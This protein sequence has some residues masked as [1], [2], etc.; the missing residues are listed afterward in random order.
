MVI[1]GA[2]GLPDRIP[3]TSQLPATAQPHQH[4]RRQTPDIAQQAPLRRHRLSEVLSAP[5][6]TES[7]RAP[8]LRPKQARRHPVAKLTKILQSTDPVSE[9]DANA[10]FEILIPVVEADP[11]AEFAT[12]TAGSVIERCRLDDSRPLAHVLDWW[13]VVTTGRPTANG[14]AHLLPE[15]L[16]KSVR[17]RM[18]VVLNLGGATSVASW[19][20]K[21][22]QLDS[23]LID[24]EGHL[25]L[26]QHSTFKLPGEHQTWSWF[27]GLLAEPLEALRA[28]RPASRPE[29]DWRELEKTLRDNGVEAGSRRYTQTKKRCQRVAD[30]LAST[31]ALQHEVE[32]W[33]PRQPPPLITEVPSEFKHAVGHLA[34]AL[35]RPLLTVNAAPTVDREKVADNLETAARGGDLS[36]RYKLAQVIDAWGAQTGL[37]I[38]SLEGEL[39][40][41]RRLMRAVRRLEAKPTTPRDLMEDINLHVLDNDL[42]EAEAALERLQ[43]E[44]ARRE[45][46]HLARQQFEGLRLKLQES[47]LRDDA[48]WRER[49]ENIE[50]RLESSDPHDMAREIGAAQTEISRQLDAMVH[51]QQEVLRELGAMLKPLGADDLQVRE[52]ERRI[53]ELERRGGRGAS[54][55]KSQIDNTLERMRSGCRTAAEERLQHVSRILTEERDDF[56]REDAGNFA[57]RLSEI[58]ALLGTETVSDEDL[59]DARDGAARL[60]RDVNDHRIHRW[61]AEQGEERL[62]EHLLD[63]CRGTLDFDA[64]DVRRLYVSLKTR[65]FVI[66]AGLTGSGKSSLTRMYAEALGAN[67]SNG[68]FRRIAVRP[69]WI[70]QTEV[71]GFVNPVSGSFVPGWLAETVRDCER[72]PDR[73]HFVLLGEMNLAPVEQYLAEWLSALEEAR[74]GSTDVR[75]P[76]YSSSLKPAN[77]D[78]W[79][80]SLRLPNNLIIVGTVNVDETTRPLSERVID[81]ANVLLLSVDMSNAHHAANGE[82]PRPWHLA[83]SEWRKVCTPEPSNEHHEFLVE[84]AAILR[85]ANIGV[86]LRAHVELERFVANANKILDPEVALDWGIVQRIIPK[87]RGFKGHLTDTLNELLEEFEG[88]G[89]E[90]SAAIVKRWTSDRYSDDEFLDGTDPRLALARISSDYDRD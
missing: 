18:A 31:I 85:Q 62:L 20:D 58:E 63:F 53:A 82:P 56:S 4:Q 10:A 70:D 52:W 50:I 88:V 33:V 49:I 76:L 86:G 44:L 12:E 22:R 59:T 89:A 38:P 23:V 51:S 21:R 9:T 71:L 47:S 6:R 54:E 28:N 81:R 67:N 69:D 37:K 39:K 34:G 74:S 68:R 27:V 66:L 36:G 24:L 43:N 64:Q 55:L 35:L 78:D 3:P 14:G 8:T 5:A 40:R 42:E 46:A 79:P 15:S 60:F 65:P 84:I 57:S 61:Q 48:G 32:P 30:D 83:V 26:D 87:I 1:Q 90:Q 73:L 29:I 16:E 25:K 7:Y 11:A 41:H 45:R 72:D 80:S 19:L 13:F 75:L 17:G 2:P 77:A